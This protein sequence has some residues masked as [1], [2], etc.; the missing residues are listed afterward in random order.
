M[1]VLNFG[2]INIDHVYRVDHFVV[3]GETLPTDSY[4]RLPG[5]KGFNQT[6]ALARAGAAVSHAGRIGTDGIWL[7]D[8][9]EALNVDTTH[10]NVGEDIP[11]GHAVIQV[12]PTGENT[13]LLHGGANHCI[14]EDDVDRILQDA[15][16]AGDA[17]LLQNEISAMPH[18]ISSAADRGLQIVL[19]P[20]PM[21]RAVRDYAL[22]HVAVLIL[23]QVECEQLT[24]RSD[25]TALDA[26][27][28][29]KRI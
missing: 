13:I 16:R 25:D 11:T 29:A 23:N 3:P 5:G 12:G 10:L 2:S 17:L 15:A 1:K 22:E 9:L 24:G 27:A 19:N 28:Q 26:L 14:A 4:Q 20:A 6:V 18:L 8:Y 7:R 21:T